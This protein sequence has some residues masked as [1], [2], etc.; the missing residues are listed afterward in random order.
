MVPNLLYYAALACIAAVC[1]QQYRI[2]FRF[3]RKFER[4]L[5]KSGTPPLRY[6]ELSAKFPKI[7][8]TAENFDRPVWFFLIVN[9]EELN[10]R[11]ALKVLYLAEMLKAHGL[12]Y[13]CVVCEEADET[14]RAAAC[15]IFERN[16]Y[17]F[18]RFPV[19]PPKIYWKY[20]RFPE[21]SGNSAVCEAYRKIRRCI[22]NFYHRNKY[23]D[24]F[25]YRLL[26]SFLLAD[27]QGFLR[28]FR[29]VLA[30]AFD[31]PNR[32]CAGVLVPMTEDEQGLFFAISLYYLRVF[33][34]N[35]AQERG[36]FVAETAHGRFLR[37]RARKEANLERIFFPLLEN[38]LARAQECDLKSF[39]RLC[40]EPFG[41]KLHLRAVGGKRRVED[42]DL[43]FLLDF[44]EMSAARGIEAFCERAG[45]LRHN[46]PEDEDFFSA[47]ALLLVFVSKILKLNISDDR[48]Y[49]G[50]PREI[51]PL[52]LTLFGKH[53]GFSD[54]DGGARNNS[55]SLRS[56]RTDFT[57]YTNERNFPK[58]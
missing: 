17:R 57:V 4:L 13:E 14:L 48:V 56:D 26:F 46:Q 31:C 5:E 52:E 58:S 29:A 32:E 3:G 12:C 10:K 50:A 18:A 51:L 36:L 42:E 1:A 45:R 27:R 25:F 23:K 15:M 39:I 9:G 33:H 54:G 16:K 40:A 49:F 53:V 19:L 2:R 38:Y 6:A 34:V 43:R 41:D 47:C 55:F 30:H 21:V 28:E 35:C 37:V 20:P 7:G 8:M 24:D 11:E 22:L 44:S